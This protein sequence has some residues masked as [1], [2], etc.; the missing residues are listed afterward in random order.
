MR[1]EV[2]KWWQPSGNGGLAFEMAKF[3]TEDMS[4]D[5]QHLAK[6]FAKTYIEAIHKKAIRYFK[7]EYTENKIKKKIS[8]VNSEVKKFLHENE[9]DEVNLYIQNKFEQLKAELYKDLP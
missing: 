4:Q 2:E 1:S 3:F 6:F 7:K 9:V 5:L 8:I